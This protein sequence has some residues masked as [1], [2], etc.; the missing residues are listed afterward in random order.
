MADSRTRAL[1]LAAY[2]IAFVALCAALTVHVFWVFIRDPGINTYDRARFG[3]VVYG[4]AYKPFVLRVLVPWMVRGLTAAL[5]ESA[6]ASL[7]EAMASDRLVQGF[8]RRGQWERELLPEYA[9]ALVLMFAALVAFVFAFR[10]LYDGVFPPS[11]W[12]K[13]L[14]TVLLLLGLPPCFY[15]ASYL[16]DFPG[17]FLY[18][19]GLGLLVRE[20][21][22]AYL[23]VFLIG[24]LNK[25]TFILLWGVFGLRYLWAKEAMP[26]RQFYA[27]AAAQLA[28]FLAVKG[29][30]TVLYGD[31]PGTSF[32]LHWFDHT[33]TLGEHLARRN[34]L[35]AMFIWIAFAL[36]AFGRWR[37]QPP[38]LKQAIAVLPV[39]LILTAIFGFLDE[40]RDYYE[41]YPVLVLMLMHTLTFAAAPSSQVEVAPRLDA[42]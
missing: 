10:W 27:L 29:A 16:S 35:P 15:Y 21:W 33:L 38:F 39:L 7:T 25:E 17:L 36:I 18:T 24:C 8:L 28:L 5:P 12:R 2:R 42:A 4:T 32:E 1:G 11:R 9:I 14:A 26:R 37:S 30:L 6:Q 3:E 23:V 13:D 40:L 31:N 19:L 20:R 22:R 34:E 41:A